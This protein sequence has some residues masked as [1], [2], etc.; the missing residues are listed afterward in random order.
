MAQTPFDSC[1][2][3]LE[4]AAQ[5]SLELAEIWN[6]YVKDHP[7][8]FALSLEGNGVYILNVEQHE[9]LPPKFAVIFGEWLFNLRSTL[10][11]IIRA[12][13]AY[14][15]GTVPPPNEDD[16]QYPIYDRQTSWERNKRRL[17]GLEAHHLEMLERMQSFASDPDANFLGWINR[18]ARID[19]H[20][21]LS[22]HHCVSGR[23]FT[24]RRHACRPH[25]D[26]AMGQPCASQRT[27]AFGTNFGY[28]LVGWA[29]CHGQP[30]GWD[31]S[32]NRRVGRLAVLVPTTLLESTPDNGAV[33]KLRDHCI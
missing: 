6:E 13:A 16:L 26:T 9:P 23:S 8:D 25:R 15:S 3:R 5:H 31:R 33:R 24:S 18:L 27:S 21:Q 7:F 28:A 22:R 1:W 17:R 20:R 10:D 2:H 19:R 11:Y 29:R 4:R 14:V 32:W 12:T 30:A